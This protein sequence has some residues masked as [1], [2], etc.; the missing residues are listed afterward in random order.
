MDRRFNFQSENRI[1][2]NLKVLDIDVHRTRDCLIV[3]GLVGRWT[4]PGPILDQ[5]SAGVSAPKTNPW[6]SFMQAFSLFGQ[7]LR[8]PQEREQ[9]THLLIAHC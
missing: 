7:W 4:V 9:I 8:A 3:H 2:I 5:R 1:S 6:S